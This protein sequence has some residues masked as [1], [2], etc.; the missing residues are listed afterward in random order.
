M[1]FLVP[2]VW[3]R[4]WKTTE[5]KYTNTMPPKTRNGEGSSKGPSLPP[6]LSKKLPSPVPR[7]RRSGGR[8]SAVSVK[9]FVTQSGSSSRGVIA[10][11][12]RDAPPPEQPQQNVPSLKH[13]KRD[14]TSA[15]VKSHSHHQANVDGDDNPL[16]TDIRAQN[17][18]IQEKDE[19]IR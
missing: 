6:M 15:P 10:P 14:E 18:V 9:A 19:L 7:Q 13:I 1:S 3:R 17:L 16:L 12:R 2:T 5:Q 11:S 8:S 4:L